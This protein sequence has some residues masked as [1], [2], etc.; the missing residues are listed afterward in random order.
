LLAFA[1]FVAAY[2]AAFVSARAFA[3]AIASPFWFPDSILLCALLLSPRRWWWVFLLGTLPGRIAPA[4]T[5]GIPAWHLLATYSIDCAAGLAT[6][7][8]LRRFMRNPLRF[9][10]LRDLA[11]FCFW[12]V[13]LIPAAD[14]ALGAW[15]DAGRGWAF[16]PDWKQWFL[17][18]ALS[19]LV[20][21]PA[22]FYWVLRPAWKIEA[23]RMR[24]LEAALL[25]AGLIATGVLAFD[26][27]LGFDEPRF[28]APVLFLV[29][30][31]VRFGMPGATGAIATIAFIAIEAAIDG[32]GPF[33]GHSPEDT[34]LALQRFLLLRAA[35]LYAVAVLVEQRGGFER[36]LQTIEKRMS[37]AAGAIK[38]K[39]CEWDVSRDLLWV[40]DPAPNSPQA[41]PV[42]LA[43][44]M[45]T[46]HPDDRER[47]LAGLETA[48]RGGGGPEG[49]YR[50]LLPDGG[51]RWM[52]WAGQVEFDD[53][54]KPL[55]VRAV[56]RDVTHLVTV[57][58]ETQ[59]QR[60]ELVH[61]SRVAMLGE[62]SGAIAHE[63]NQPLGAILT[64]AQTAK[65]LLARASF[66]PKE[67][68]E[69]LDDIVADDHRAVET[70]RGL[71]QLFQKAPAQQKTR[72]I[73]LN[74]VVR[75]VLKLAQ[76]E[77]QIAKVALHTELSELPSID[78][79]RIQLQQLLLNL[80]SNACNAMAGVEGGR[81]LTVR[82]NFNDG[83]GVHVIVSDR[84][85]GIP[86]DNLSHLFDPFFTTRPG[87]MGLGLTVCRTIASAHHGRLW[88]ENNPDRG[89]SFHFVVPWRPQPRQ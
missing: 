60:D 54:G 80:I 22:L 42:T 88:A 34:A 66:D 57:E 58:Q 1:L 69:I 73:D 14:A 39:I 6:A 64:N 28:F 49:R 89:A 50:T 77:L 16:G 7:L 31:A 3:P 79:D 68:S 33:S 27:Q 47:A 26:T 11:V 52:A 46:M 12:A 55:W 8:A 81:E 59:L 71:R 19:Q 45:Q 5:H 18:V 75:D 24:W 72:P 29:W 15:A 83:E 43:E 38:L 67:L 23:D 70:I 40:I 87:G 13:A 63:L 84:G 78:G 56:G 74:L 62:M 10:T 61:L 51:F 17:G 48:M 86:A 41:A 35:P 36:S 20:I 82:T 37:L 44:F 32:R 65:R 2:Q 76:S 30:A 9:E 4:I 85:D 21:T 25:A 53:A